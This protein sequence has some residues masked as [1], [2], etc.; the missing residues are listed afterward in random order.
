MIQSPI[1]LDLLHPYRGWPTGSCSNSEPERHAHAP[2]VPL[3]Q[4]TIISS[5]PTLEDPEQ[6][7]LGRI[8]MVDIRYLSQV[9]SSHSPAPPER[10]FKLKVPSIKPPAGY[11]SPMSCRV[12]QDRE[13]FVAETRGKRSPIESII[14]SIPTVTT[15]RSTP[16]MHLPTVDAPWLSR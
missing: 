10:P 15:T 12:Y 16:C 3:T 14:S 8:T 5:L 11:S 6:L 13:T 2:E 1:T 9:L 7:F 4:H